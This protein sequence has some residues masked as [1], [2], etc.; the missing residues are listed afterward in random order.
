MSPAS[1]T[2]FPLLAM[3]LATSARSI[4]AIPMAASRAPMVVGIR[5][6]SKATKVGMSRVRSK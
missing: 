3:M 4:P 1:S 2:A 6:T 5:Q